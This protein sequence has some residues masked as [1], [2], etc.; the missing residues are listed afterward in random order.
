MRTK[1]HGAQVKLDAKS[2]G[3]AVFIDANCFVYAA[4]SDPLYGPPCQKLLKNAENKTIQAFSSA[5][6][7]GDL[8]HRLMTIEAALLLARPMAGIA[9]WLRRHPAEVQ[10]LSQ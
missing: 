5:H 10:R 8:V 3:S 2:P 1:T 7:L 6:V 9:N 4:T